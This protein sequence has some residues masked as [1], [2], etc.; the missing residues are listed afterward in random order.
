MSLTDKLWCTFCEN[1]RT[2]I[3]SWKS[4]R[5]P[6]SCAGV[7]RWGGVWFLMK[8][9]L[10]GESWPSSLVH[11]DWWN[12]WQIVNREVVQLSS[13]DSLQPYTERCKYSSFKTYLKTSSANPICLVQVGIKWRIL[14]HNSIPNPIVFFN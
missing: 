13:F 6:M 12:S 1:Y 9:L 14:T 10:F 7:E 2:D 11:P 3:A 4:D 5:A 8:Y